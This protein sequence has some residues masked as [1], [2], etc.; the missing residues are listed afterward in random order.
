LGRNRTPTLEGGE[1]EE[2]AQPPLRHRAFCR[3]DHVRVVKTGGEGIIYGEFGVPKGIPFYVGGGEG[4]YAF[5]FTNR[6]SHD[7]AW[8]GPFIHQLNKK[9]ELFVQPLGRIRKDPPRKGVFEKKRCLSSRQGKE[10]W[11]KRE[12]GSSWKKEQIY[13]MLGSVQG[14]GGGSCGKTRPYLEKKQGANSTPERAS[15]WEGGEQIGEGGAF[16][17]KG[18]GQLSKNK[19]ERDVPRTV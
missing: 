4:L 15:P 2:S 3:N 12:K 7:A 6:E 13:L 11:R 10:R 17:Q 1:R 5:V 8:G 14:R 19:E 16:T 18:S 9:K